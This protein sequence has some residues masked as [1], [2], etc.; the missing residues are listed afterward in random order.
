MKPGPATM[1]REPERGG[2]EHLVEVHDTGRRRRLPPIPV[3]G[4][5]RI[6]GYELALVH[7]DGETEPRWIAAERLDPRQH[8]PQP[9]RPASQTTRSAMPLSMRRGPR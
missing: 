8:G 1:R 4:N 9:S 6:V 3:P 7:V 5:T 2:R